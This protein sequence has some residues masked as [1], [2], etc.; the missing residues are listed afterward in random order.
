MKIQLLD[1]IPVSFQLEMYSLVVYLLNL[2]NKFIITGK[3]LIL[4]QFDWMADG[5]IEIPHL[6]IGCKK[7]SP[8]IWLH[9]WPTPPS[10]FKAC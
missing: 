8:K 3:T 7:L 2:F 6:L 1:V 5:F 10:G 9:V 4:E